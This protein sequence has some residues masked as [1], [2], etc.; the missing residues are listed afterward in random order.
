ML[1][2]CLVNEFN[3]NSGIEGT[4]IHTR[5]NELFSDEAAKK[6]F[7]ELDFVKD[8]AKCKH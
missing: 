6:R 1:S 2:K 3:N 7:W 4:A 5:L 8:A